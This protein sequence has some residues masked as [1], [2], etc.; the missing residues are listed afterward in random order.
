MN[1]KTIG[2]AVMLV[3]TACLLG[4]VSPLRSDDPATRL[5]AVEKITSQDDLFLIAMNLGLRVGGLSGGKCDVILY[6]EHY[7]ED[8]RVAAVKRIIDPV[9]LIKCATWADGDVYC[10]PAVEQGTFEYN[11]ELY[12]VRDA[13]RS[14]K[15]RVAHG[16]A[17]RV[18]AE[19]RLCDGI[20]FARIPGALEKFNVDGD[21]CT[22]KKTLNI[23]AGLFPGKLRYCSVGGEENAFVDCYTSVK[24]DN[25][26]NAVLSR[27][28]SVQKDQSA[29]CAFVIASRKNGAEVYP[30]AVEA[31]IG[32]LDGSDQSAIVRAFGKLYLSG[33]KCSVPASWGWKLLN[34]IEKPSDDCMIAMAKLGYGAGRGS[35]EAKHSEVDHIAEAKFSDAVWS[36]CYQDDLFAGYSRRKMVENIRT[37]DGMARFLVEVRKIN[38]DDVGA[39]FARIKDVDTLEKIKRDCYLKVVAEKAKLL[40]FAL[41]YQQRLE[42]IS[43]MSLKVERALAANEFMGLMKEAE[44]E[45]SRKRKLSVLL[46]KWINVGLD[47][48]VAEAAANSDL[49]FSVAGFH[50]GMKSEEAKLL[51][52]CRYPNEEIAWTADAKGV[53]D[54]INFGTTFLAKVYKF[55]AQTWQDWIYAFSENTGNRF[56]GDE[57][58]DEKKPI[59]GRGT[60]VKVSQ[61]IWRCQDNRRDMTITYFGDKTVQE[62][63]PE[64]SGFVESVF[65][66]ARGVTGGDI[67][68]EVVLEGARHWANKGWEAGIGGCP[69]M[70]RIE[71]GTVGPGGT[72]KIVQ[73]ARKVELE[74]TA[75]SVKDAWN[76][77]KDAAPAVE[78]FMN[79]LL[80]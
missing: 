61:R 8:V 72:R 17:V 80:K 60:V 65:K 39:A 16:D 51:F 18:A 49:T 76:A 9:R 59:G 78:N 68:K 50:L 28:V 29:L 14:L 36:K 45:E 57:L 41:T 53:V 15:E 66:I 77:M 4:C 54:R 56:V 38:V 71:R 67:V 22:D 32:A 27:V 25:P 21:T 75:D 19:R 42:A 20:M 12:W 63:E 23:R 64:A 62:I 58:K 52:E 1:L 7:E 47:Q 24:K 26:L 5:N 11:G 46:L 13:E 34:K 10:D 30:D 74:R 69:G 2:L 31:A 73:P 48:I 37:P 70:L 79:N 40:L 35:G 6:P 33:G 43:R 3:G 44:I 55:D